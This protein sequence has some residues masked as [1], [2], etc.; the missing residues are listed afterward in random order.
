MF[1]CKECLAK[2]GL[3]GVLVSHGPCEDCGKTR[4]CVDAK[5]PRQFMND[6]PFVHVSSGGTRFI[7]ERCDFTK[8]VKVHESA[9]L[10]REGLMGDVAEMVGYHAVAIHPE[11]NGFAG[12]DCITF[13]IVG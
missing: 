9:S 6:K 8:P 2:R 12:Y 5:P 13:E 4:A 3:S 10:T 11:L 7:C 1:L